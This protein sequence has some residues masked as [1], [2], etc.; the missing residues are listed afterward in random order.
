MA[1]TTC[2]VYAFSV[3]Q[4]SLETGIAGTSTGVY[5]G[6]GL[7]TQVFVVS[8]SVAGAQAVLQTQYGSDIAHIEGPVQIVAGALTSATGPFLAESDQPPAPPPSENP[9]PSKPPKEE[10]HSVFGHKKH[11]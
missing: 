8:Q 1:N 10:H 4:K 3:W 5:Q 6:Q 9:A 7:P 11:G 2:N